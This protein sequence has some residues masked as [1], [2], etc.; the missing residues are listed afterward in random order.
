MAK[1]IE[2]HYYEGNNISSLN[3]FVKFY[4]KKITN[5]CSVNNMTTNL[6]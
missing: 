5:L 4:M 6:L 2:W 1:Y 3:N